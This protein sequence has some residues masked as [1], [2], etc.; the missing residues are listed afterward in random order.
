MRKQPRKLDLD[1]TA[2]FNSKY[3]VVMA[4]DGSSDSGPRTAHII[5]DYNQMPYADETFDWAEGCC[6]LEGSDG[7]HW[8]QH[9][10]EDGVEILKAE[11]EGTIP[12]DPQTGTNNFVELARVLK[13]GAK[14]RVGACGAYAVLK[15]RVV[16]RI[17][18]DFDKETWK[19][20]GAKLALSTE[21]VAELDFD[22]VANM[23]EDIAR[24]VSAMTRAGFDV[25]VE[26]EN[27][28]DEPAVSQPWYHLTRI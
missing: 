23:M 26:Y 2:G 13:H 17:E 16:E 3:A 28:G 1:G 25:R 20:T 11:Q 5:G 22:G 6:Y 14:A 19:H 8:Y 9:R 15:E 10:H 12:I 7:T 4:L 18:D 24:N 21:C 27:R